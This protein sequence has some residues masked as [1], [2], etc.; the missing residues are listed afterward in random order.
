MQGGK[1][2]LSTRL[3]FHLSMLDLWTQGCGAFS[4]LLSQDPPFSAH[5]YVGRGHGVFLSLWVYICLFFILV[6]NCSRTLYKMVFKVTNNLVSV[7]MLHWNLIDFNQV[8][9]V[10]SSG[11]KWGQKYLVLIPCSCTHTSV[12]LGLLPTF[13]N[14]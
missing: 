4:K 7:A 1:W 14:Y 5:S 6:I 10:L 2:I 12:I 8:M 9:R 13:S 3:I 11:T